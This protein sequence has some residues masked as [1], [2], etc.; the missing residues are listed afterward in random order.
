MNDRCHYPTGASA[1][2]TLTFSISW[3]IIE[4]IIVRR[5]D[6]PMQIHPTLIRS[7][8]VARSIRVA[9]LNFHFH[10]DMIAGRYSIVKKLSE[11]STCEVFLV[12]DLSNNEEVVIKKMQKVRTHR[13]MDEIKIT[14]MLNNETKGFSRLR[15]HFESSEHIVTIHY[16]LVYIVEN[17]YELFCTVAL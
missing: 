3:I 11:G 15:D 1:N 16:Y 12:V 7:A 6:P 8:I 4:D 5:R 17:H 10:N 14:Q 9:K 13:I 2:L